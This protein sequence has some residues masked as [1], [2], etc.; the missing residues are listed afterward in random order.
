[1]TGSTNVLGGALL[2]AGAALL[3]SPA[4]AEEVAMYRPAQG[5]SHYFGSKHVVGYFLEA[6]GACA[7]NLFL[8]EN[9][10]EA[11]PSASRVQFKVLPGENIK[12]TSAEGQAIE[13]KCG[14]NASTLE[15]K[16]GN[17]KIRTVRGRAP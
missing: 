7:V 8:A 3:A 5:V 6:N 12:L 13:M 11:A 4:A 17:A 1:M 10:V 2:L 15:V 16:A 9:T 14:A